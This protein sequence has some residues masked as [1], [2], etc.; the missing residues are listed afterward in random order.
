MAGLLETL[1]V[2]DEDDMA[3]SSVAREMDV[4]GKEEVCRRI[5]CS[6]QRLRLGERVERRDATSSAQITWSTR[7][8]CAGSVP[9]HHLGAMASPYTSSSHSPPPLQHPVPTHPAFIPEPPSTPNSP[10]GYMRYTS[11]P[12]ESVPAAD[13]YG[14]QQPHSQPSHMPSQHPQ[15][16]G[17]APNPYQGYGAGQPHV[18]PQQHQRHQQ[19]PPLGE[20]IDFAQFGVNPTT[21]Q[22]GMQLGQSAVAAGQEYMQKNV[23]R[24]PFY[25]NLECVADGHKKFGGH[26][27]VPLL[28]HHFNVSN[29]YVIKKLQVVLL[30]WRRDW[31]RIRRP[32]EQGVNQWLPPRDD[33]NSPDLYIPG[34]CSYC[35]QF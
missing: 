26:I 33:I 20:G 4:V 31:E 11:S 14:S 3:A 10:Q 24:S 30:P 25:S 13:Y 32:G 28:K 18:R 17:Y 8:L 5:F 21:A 23:R 27:P 6:S 29:S 1:T 12:A 35:S 9:Y 19:H 7:L 16:S 22:F 34:E 15:S 2:E